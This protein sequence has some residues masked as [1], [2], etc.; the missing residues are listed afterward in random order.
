MQLRPGSFIA[1]LCAMKEPFQFRR[2]LL[3]VHGGIF[4]SEAWAGGA[5]AESVKFM[6]NA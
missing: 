2:S 3:S 4:P 1:Y 6:L 5:C